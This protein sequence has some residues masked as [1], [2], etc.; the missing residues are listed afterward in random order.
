MDLKEK[1]R[2]EV[3][4]SL[5]GVSVRRIQ[6]L[7]QEGIISTE[8]AVI[9]GRRCRAYELESTIQKY[10]QYLSDKA[11]GKKRAEREML[12][13]EQKLE[14]EVALKESQGELHR[15]KTEIA[16]GKYI[17]IEEVRMDY[18]KFFIVFKKFAV[19]LPARIAGM[20]SGSLEPVE[21]R[22]LE[23]EIAEEINQLLAAFVV[24]GYVE[25]AEDGEKK[26]KHPNP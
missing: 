19:S 4:A 16:A 24:A 2:V 14:A 18:S 5:F 15:I 9:N 23:K 13:K 7:T 10:A 25:Q 17:S 3:I 11:H 21:A 6:Q 8:P 12:L 1:C 22:R 20:L 26:K